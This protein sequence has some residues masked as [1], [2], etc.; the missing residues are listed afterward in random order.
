GR[1]CWVCTV[2]GSCRIIDN[3]VGGADGSGG[4]VGPT[5]VP[6][7][8]RGDIGADELGCCE[9]LQRVISVKDDAA[10]A[11]VDSE[12]KYTCIK[13]GDGM[14]SP[15][16]SYCNAPQD[17]PRCTPQGQRYFADGNRECCPGLN[18]I[19]CDDGTEK[20]SGEV[21]GDGVCG[22]D[23][24]GCCEGDCMGMAMG[25]AIGGDGTCQTI[26]DCTGYPVPAGCTDGGNWKCDGLQD[27]TAQARKDDNCAY[28]CRENLS[29]CEDNTWCELY[30][31]CDNPDGRGLGRCVNR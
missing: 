2:I 11:C 8:Q 12:E 21:C 25:G 29:V 31:R 19:A 26:D 6:Q 16:E 10:N 1:T 17:C 4:E 7:G 23:E 22:P 5:C 28:V 24:A 30:E 3:P 9:G 27:Y 13:L 20:C 14:C 18:V 15:N